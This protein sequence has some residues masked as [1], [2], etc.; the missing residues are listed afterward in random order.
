MQVFFRRISTSASAQSSEER[1]YV[2]TV[3][4]VQ[5]NQSL[6]VILTDSKATLHPIE[7]TYILL[8]FKL[9]IYLFTYLF[10][11]LYLSL[12]FYLSLYLSFSF[13]SFF[14]SLI[15]PHT[16]TCSHLPPPPPHTH[17]HIFPSP[18]HKDILI[19]PTLTHSHLIT[20]HPTQH[21]PP[22][23]IKQR[24]FRPERKGL[25]RESHVWRSQT[26]FYIMEL[27]L[28]RLKFFS[29]GSTYYLQVSYVF[30]FSNF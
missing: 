24:Y 7:C 21:L 17:T 8:I 4:D 16:Q 19:S 18:P 27:K 29:S 2:G 10:F 25:I 14:F 11:T 5:L 23:K 28:G 26:I 30:F 3:R 20:P 6:A 22:L 9:F 13:Y 1:E 12:S 15:S